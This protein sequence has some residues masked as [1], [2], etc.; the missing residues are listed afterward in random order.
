MKKTFFVTLILALFGF[1]NIN[2]QKVAV[3][4]TEYI[5]EKI[6]EYAAAQKKL[7]DLSQQ[8]ENEVSKMIAEVEQLYKNYQADKIILSSEMAAKRE[9]E[10]QDKERQIAEFRKAKFGK[11]GALYQER[12]KLVKPIQDK[13]YNAIKKVAETGKY[14]IILDSASELSVLYVD[15]K[16]DISDEVLKVLGYE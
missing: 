6:P 8:W 12:Q 10:I 13:V 2:A 3:V 9:M 7:N 16:Y 5:L 15:M 4:N 1:T 14:M 11:N